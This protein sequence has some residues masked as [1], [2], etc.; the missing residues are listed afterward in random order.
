MSEHCE[1]KK[2]EEKALGLKEAEKASSSFAAYQLKKN[3]ARQRKCIGSIGFPVT[4]TIGGSILFGR[5]FAAEGCVCSFGTSPSTGGGVDVPVQV[6]T[7]RR[8]AYVRHVNKRGSSVA[9]HS[10]R[11]SQWQKLLRRPETP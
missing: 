6:A 9:K 11:F 4:V 3:V 1:W 7:K 2:E 5:L 10:S 8:A